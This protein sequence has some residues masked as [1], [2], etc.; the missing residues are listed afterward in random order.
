M[1]DED[2]PKN[3]EVDEPITTWIR[4][5]ETEDAHD[6]GYESDDDQKVAAC[7]GSLTKTVGREIPSPHK[8]MARRSGT[9][10][11][12]DSLGDLSKVPK[13][14]LQ[15]SLFRK[16][17]PRLPDHGPYDHEIKL[18]EGAQLRFFKSYHLNL[19]QAEALRGYIEE[20][21]KNGLIRESQSP[22]G[23]PVLFVPR[24]GDGKLRMVVDYRSLN[25]DTTKNRYHSIGC[26]QPRRQNRAHTSPRSG[27]RT[28][29]KT[30]FPPPRLA[31]ALQLHNRSHPLQIP[32]LSGVGE[33]GST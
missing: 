9:T 8:K 16:K 25:D 10:P 20:N 14:Y 28:H 18:K 6:S 5:H 32:P 30:Q 19:A 2:T 13:E 17:I 24:K 12:D 27:L 21:L 7:Y 11:H 26:F 15:Y 33:P 4:F 31:L 1:P 23:Y 3:A 29:L 22:V